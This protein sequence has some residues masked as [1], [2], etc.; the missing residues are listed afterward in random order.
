VTVDGRSLRR[1]KGVAVIPL[2][3]VAA[4]A[5]VGVGLW[6]QGASA[7]ASTGKAAT[8]SRSHGGASPAERL[9]AQ[10]LDG[11]APFSPERSDVTSVL[12]RQTTWSDLWTTY[13]H[14][15]WINPARLPAP[16]TAVYVFLI[17]GTIT[18]GDA[19]AGNVPPPVSSWQILVDSVTSQLPILEIAS[20]DGAPAPAWFGDLSGTV[21]TFVR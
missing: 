6:P 17:H 14:A 18:E 1:L 15:A 16:D 8:A 7:I 19:G 9:A 20:N 11:T 12:E 21:T 4:L 5:A 10:I 2:I 3:L 13:P